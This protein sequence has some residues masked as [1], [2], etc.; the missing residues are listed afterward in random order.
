MRETQ[1][2]SPGREYLLEKGMATYSCILAW[3]IP[4]TEKPGRNE[5]QRAGH[6]W[7]N[8]HF[9]FS[10]T[11]HYIFQTIPGTSIIVL[12][13]IRSSKYYLIIISVSKL[14]YFKYEH[15]WV[16]ASYVY[17][18]PLHFFWL[19]LFM[20][21]FLKGTFWRNTGS[22]VI[23]SSLQISCYK[24]PVSHPSLKSEPYFVFCNSIPKI[25]EKF[26]C[27]FFVYRF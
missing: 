22:S 27:L 21:N 13:G 24:V 11:V 6:D 1:V 26:W 14:G 16:F 5:L 12:D 19:N 3:R 23:S 15:S 18:I 4:W 9:H 20:W 25:A 10:I 7:N 8:E 17:N 2:W